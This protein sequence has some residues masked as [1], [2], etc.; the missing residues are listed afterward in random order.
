[1]TIKVKQSEYV[2]LDFAANRFHL[3][4]TLD[5]VSGFAVLC[6]LLV[7][8]ADFLVSWSTAAVVAPSIAWAVCVDAP[9][10]ITLTLQLKQNVNINFDIG[11][12]GSQDSRE[13][14]TI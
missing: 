10:A 12:T 2:G 3:L 9:I 4:R 13:Q 11:A 5:A 14:R 1:M 8:D 6:V 7:H